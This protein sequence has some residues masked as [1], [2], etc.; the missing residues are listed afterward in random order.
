MLVP[1][2]VPSLSRKLGLQLLNR[3]KYH[4]INHH[5]PKCSGSSLVH[6]FSVRNPLG[7]KKFHNHATIKASQVPSLSFV[8]N[9]VEIFNFRIMLAK[10]YMER[11]FNLISGHVPYF[12]YDLANHT[13]RRITILRDPVERFLSAYSIHVG[14]IESRVNINSL[15][16][17]FLDSDRAKF[18]GRIQCAFVSG[19]V[20]P[21]I[22]CIGEG[23]LVKRALDSSEN[24]DLI[25]LSE[26]IPEFNRNL[27]SLFNINIR[28]SKTRNINNKYRIRKDMIDNNIIKIIKDICCTDIEFYNEI[29]KNKV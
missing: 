24:F 28:I 9:K 6:A 16:E 5:I 22:L 21:D 14:K 15:L 2:F 23:N 20:S 26:S 17:E 29:S 1:G 27:N 4:I 10:Y 25:G 13:Y 8:Q 3:G 11:G 18:W 12:G 7:C 19:Q